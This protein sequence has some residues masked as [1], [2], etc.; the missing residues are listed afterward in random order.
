MCWGVLTTAKTPLP[1]EHIHMLMRAHALAP[2]RRS[3][4]RQVTQRTY[5]TVRHHTVA[6]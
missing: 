3:P 2:V 4:E 1:Q 6:L 5:N